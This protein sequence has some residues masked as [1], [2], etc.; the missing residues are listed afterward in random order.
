MRTQ[1]LQTLQ[2]EGLERIPVLGLP[3][4]PAFSEAVGTQAGRGPRARPRRGAG[5]AAR[6]PPPRARGARLA[7]GRRPAP[8]GRRPR[9]AGR[10]EELIGADEARA[11]EA[12]VAEITA[13]DTV[14]L[15]ENDAARDLRQRRGERTAA[16][17][18]DTTEQLGGGTRPAVWPVRRSTRPGR[19]EHVGEREADLR[20][21]HHQVHVRPRR[22][23]LRERQLLRPAHEQVD[24]VGAVEDEGAPPARRAAPGC[25]SGSRRAR[26]SG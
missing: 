3:F 16:E 13:A 15:D 1:L 24:G 4:D 21:H 19:S 25:R 23:V 9:R 5:D 22:V 20:H 17:P 6:L 8:R 12:A 7:R 26:R 2:Q 10:A 14:P 18:P 11:A